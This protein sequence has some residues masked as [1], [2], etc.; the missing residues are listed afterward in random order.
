MVAGKQ[1]EEQDKQEHVNDVLVQPLGHYLHEFHV[2]VEVVIVSLVEFVDEWD[3]LGFVHAVVDVERRYLNYCQG[4][5]KAAKLKQ[6]CL[7]V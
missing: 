3:L 2:A 4:K 1:G 7:V 6:N 5:S